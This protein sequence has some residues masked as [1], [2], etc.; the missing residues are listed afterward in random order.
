MNIS[1]ITAG[2]G[3]DLGQE[4]SSEVLSLATPSPSSRGFIAHEPEHPYLAEAVRRAAS[5]QTEAQARAVRL[6]VDAATAGQFGVLRNSNP[7]MLTEEFERS[8]SEA[9]AEIAERAQAAFLS[10]V[11]TASEQ[12][13]AKL[14]FEARSVVHDLNQRDYISQ[15]EFDERL[16]AECK[17]LCKGDELKARLL[18]SAALGD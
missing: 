15:A 3:E 6:V 18:V 12:R 9:R 13:T 5:P 4:K 1:P 17:R 2:L 10:V 11:K 7:N 8:E 14:L 16:I